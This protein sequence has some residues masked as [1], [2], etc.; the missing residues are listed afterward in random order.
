MVG[1]PSRFGRYERDTKPAMH[2]LFL[3]RTVR[4]SLLKCNRV[5]RGDLRVRPHL[6]ILFSNVFLSTRVQVLVIAL[7][8]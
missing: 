1:S 5:L 3:E 4:L 7:V 2:V 6:F 8:A